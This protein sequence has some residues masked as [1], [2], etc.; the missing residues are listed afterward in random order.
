MRGNRVRQFAIVL[1]GLML[2]AACGDREVLLEGE[3]LDLDGT[4]AAKAVVSRSEPISLPGAVANAEWTHQQGNVRHQ[5]SNLALPRDLNLAWS[6]PIGQGNDRRHRITA[7]P[8]VA[9]GRIYTLDSRALVSAHDLNGRPLWTRDLTPS[10]DKAEDASGGGL[11]ASGGTVFATTGFGTLVAIEAATGQLLWTQDL[12]SKASGAPTV[13]EG[14][15]YLVTRNDVGWAIDAA[16]GRILWQTL[17]AIAEAG[18]TGGSSPA[19]A[20][21]LV[22][23]PFSSGQ[24][25]A[26]ERGTGRQAWSASVAGQKAGRAYSRFSDL[27]GAP[28]VEGNA[29]FAAT[30]SG[31]AGARDLATGQTLWSAREGTAHGLLVAGGSVFMVS[32]DN[33]LLRLDAAAGE[34]IWAVDLPYYERERIK[35]RLSIFVHRGPIMV[36][37]RLMLVSNDGY[38]REFN[39]VDGALLRAVPMPGK[40]AAGP[41]VAGQTL[42]VVT[43]KGDLQAFR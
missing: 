22:I 26:V 30:H 3:R 21:A 38:L 16:N 39:P 32:D 14:V 19:I 7:E 2:V 37:G 20:G 28:V 27:S 4:A 18:V 1:A 5:F 25:I 42:Y 29:V 17:G 41:V 11:A 33:R 13:H 23:F 43:E 34:V 24:L 9:G 31:R 10:S 36:A 15:V 8:I 6:T 12:N 40:A 35:K